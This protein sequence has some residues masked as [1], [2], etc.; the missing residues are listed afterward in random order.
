MQG[1]QTSQRQLSGGRCVIPII[2][3]TLFLIYLNVPAVLSTHHGVPRAVVLL[4]PLLLTLPVAYRV[5]VRGEALRFPAMIVAAMLMLACHAVSATLS[6]RPHIGMET[7]FS[8]LSEGV[9]L[10]FLLVNA[11]R[12]RE[13]VL[14]AARSIVAAGALMGLIV[15]VQQ[16][17]GPTQYPMAGFGQVD[18]Q[19]FT[20]AQH[21]LAGPIGEK[22]RF[23]Q[24]LA[25]LIPLAAGLALTAPARRRWLY[26]AA[27]L[28]LC[29]GVA[30]SFSRG[31]MLALVLAIPFALLFGLLRFRHL[32]IAGIGLGFLL[33][34]T[35]FIGAMP[36]LVDRVASIGEVAAQSLG[37]K[38][39]GFRNADG[40]SRGRVTEMQ[41]A[42]LL[43]LDYPILGAGPGMA[44]SYYPEYAVL[45]GGK[46]RPNERR[47]HSLYLQLAAETGVIGLCAFLLVMLMVLLPLDHA[48]RQT[49]HNDRQLWGLVCGLE[50]GMLIF[51]FTSI[52]LHAAYIRYAWLF[53][54]LAVAAAVL[55]YRIRQGGFVTLHK[56]N[57]PQ[58]GSRRSV[59][60]VTN[61]VP[62][63]LH[64][65]HS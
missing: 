22:N 8:W 43:F 32:T 34:L 50:L 13:E 27:I 65:N 58:G 36:Q 10:A 47:T 5:L 42:G 60:A 30:L 59:L 61:V 31:A 57:T 1:N 40:A 28:L 52:F 11:L 21:R 37:L 51:L 44:P 19:D 62:T 18:A 48:R 49:Q 12:S 54:A 38:P 7:V 45:V 15:L 3:V 46:V 24:V 53:L 63:P 26:F 56:N 55:P 35:P 39:G 9:L 41:A 16:L 25:V 2:S 17:L 4:V 33:M 29:I 6:A 20:G 23:A 14:V 64:S